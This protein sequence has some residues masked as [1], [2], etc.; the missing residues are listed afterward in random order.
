ML[1]RAGN[2][3]ADTLRFVGAVFYW[4]TRKTIYVLG[5]R[6]SHCPCQNIS[7]DSI[8]GRV[9]CDAILHW[10]DPARF[11]KVCPLL[12]NTPSGW[13]CS[14]H[15]SQVRPFWGRVVRWCAL[16][17]LIL[18]LAGTIVAFVGLRVVGQAP[19]S[20]TQVVWPGRWPEIRG[21]QSM[22]LFSQAIA[23]FQQGRLNEAY[24]ALTSSRQRDPSNYDATLLL[25]QITMFQRSYSFSDDMFA[26]LWRDHPDQRPRTAVVYHDSLLSLDRMNTLA[27]S[28]V[29]MAKMDSSRAV[30]WVRSAL[31]AIRSM[32]A[33]EAGAFATSQLIP[34]QALAPHAQLLLRTELALRR[35]GPRDEA[36]AALRG[37]FAGPINPFYTEYQITRLAE[38]GAHTEAQRLLD[39]LGPILGTFE[40][41]LTQVAIATIAG[42]QWAARGAFRSLL[43]QPL[44]QTKLERLACLLIAHPDATLY[45]ELNTRLQGDRALESAADSAALWISG[46]IC[47][48]PVEASYWQTRSQPPGARFPDIKTV[49]FS[50]RNLAEANTVTHLVNVVSFPREVVIALLWRVAPQATP[51]TR[52][53]PASKL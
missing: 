21:V 49:N 39:Q 33:E 16:S 20:W 43:K 44:N 36:V 9:R 42:D 34:L 3:L 10:H 22:H 31:L 23:S 50:S 52:A 4:N 26:N 29:A 51:D 41:L 37:Q 2:W 18:Y 8:P 6:T 45:R 28:S 32:R 1:R 30:V 40:Q 14:V 7:D 5:G 24:L 17:L 19:V 53:L 46:V 47:Q 11:Q 25:A 48:A 12:V 13:R 38:L 15:A 35:G 27:A